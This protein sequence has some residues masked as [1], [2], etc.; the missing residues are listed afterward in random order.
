MPTDR[1]DRLSRDIE[2][3]VWKED[4]VWKAQV[5]SYSEDLINEPDRYWHSQSSYIKMRTFKTEAAAK[6]WERKAKAL[7]E[8][9]EPPG[10]MGRHGFREAVR[11]TQVRLRELGKGWER[12]R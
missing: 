5:A 11:N 1:G 2:S 9:T 3:K 10:V 12:S 6:Q 7:A 8:R 4:G